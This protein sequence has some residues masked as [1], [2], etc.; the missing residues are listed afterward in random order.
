MQLDLGTE[1]NQD[2]MLMF[3][4]MNELG[5]IKQHFDFA[6]Q[7][8]TSC[9]GNWECAQ[10]AVGLS[11]GCN[12][13]DLRQDGLLKAHVGYGYGVLGDHCISQA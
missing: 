9:A 2:Q 6:H 10:H 13:L 8:E 11:R 4:N 3:L 1:S 7:Q 5:H 12:K